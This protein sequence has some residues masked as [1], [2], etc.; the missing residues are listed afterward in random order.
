M[1]DVLTAAQR[2]LNMS[3]IRGKNTKPEL[4]VRRLLHAA[5]LRFR[6][7]RKDLPGSPDLTFAKQK[8]VIFVHGCYWQG[9][10]CPKFKVP[11]AR[12]EFWLGKSGGTKLGMLMQLAD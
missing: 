3:R 7:H 11:K 4:I 8:A 1:V 5:G 9:H 6:L 10:A 2:R 12:T